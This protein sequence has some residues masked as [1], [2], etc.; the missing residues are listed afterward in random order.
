MAQIPQTQ[1]FSLIQG[2]AHNRKNCLSQNEF[3]FISRNYFVSEEKAGKKTISDVFSSK[4]SQSY[5]GHGDQACEEEIQIVR[6][7]GQSQ[8][9][10]GTNIKWLTTDFRIRQVFLQI[11]LGI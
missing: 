5:K 10:V 11:K 6:W 2:V 7:S 1:V 9:Q 4:S 8:K 3:L